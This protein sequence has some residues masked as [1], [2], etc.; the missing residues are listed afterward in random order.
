MLVLQAFQDLHAKRID[1]AQKINQNQNQIAQL[2]RTIKMASLTEE[3]LKGCS[4]ETRMYKGVG[5]M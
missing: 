3:E 4:V 5:R 1:T 2:Q